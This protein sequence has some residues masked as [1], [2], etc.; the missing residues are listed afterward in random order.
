MLAVDFITIIITNCSDEPFQHHRQIEKLRLRNFNKD[1]GTYY[2]SGLFH[3]L[4]IL[5]F[6]LLHNS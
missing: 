6:L 5:V 4:R 3:T 1:K 2:V